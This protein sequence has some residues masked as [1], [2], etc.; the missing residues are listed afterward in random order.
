VNVIIRNSR[1]HFDYTLVEVM[2]ILMWLT[3]NISEMTSKVDEHGL[4]VIYLVQKLIAD[5]I[6]KDKLPK[7]PHVYD[8]SEYIGTGWRYYIIHS[9]D[10]DGEEVRHSVIIV[11]DDSYAVHLRLILQ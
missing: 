10:V 8:G 5:G 7:L 2:D 1:Q 4:N 9:D 11:D 3:A 6:P